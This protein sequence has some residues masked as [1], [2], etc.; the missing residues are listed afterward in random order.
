MEV[1]NLNDSGPGSY[2]AAISAS[3]PRTIVFRVSGVI[4]LQS[5]CIVGNGYVTIAGQTAPGDGI[6]LANWRAGCSGPTDVI[7]RYLHIRVG[8]HAQQSMDAMSPSSA[9]QSIFRPHHVQLVA[10]RGV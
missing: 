7:M 9:T 3:G 4:W 8:D 6:C 2:R 1:T 10:G 5:Q